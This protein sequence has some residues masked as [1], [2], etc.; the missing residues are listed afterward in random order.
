M[1]SEILRRMHFEY[2]GIYNEFSFRQHSGTFRLYSVT[3]FN[4][5]ISN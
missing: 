4:T 1:L 5:G 3:G 2:P